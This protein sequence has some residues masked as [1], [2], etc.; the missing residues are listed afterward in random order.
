MPSSP[1]LLYDGDC[2]FCRAWVARLRRWDRAGRVRCVPARER[3]ALPELPP[4]ADAELDRA[5]H[6]VT[7]DGRV[8]VG[9][10]ALPELLRHLPGGRWIRPLL[11]LPGVP[12]L[13][14]RAYAGVARRRH[15]LGCGSGRCRWNA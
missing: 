9:S 10:R 5:V 6:L 14:D 2:A 1:V 15:R 11:L 8:H 4:I 3:G 7:P 12:A 13:A